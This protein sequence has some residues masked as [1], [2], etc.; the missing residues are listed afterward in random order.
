M[1]LL[2]LLLPRLPSLVLSCSS[3]AAEFSAVTP[4]GGV[5][6]AAAAVCVQAWAVMEGKEGDLSLAR[7]L[8]LDGLRADPY[9][10]AL[11]TVYAIIERQDGSD[12]KARKVGQS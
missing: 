12:G 9:H 8:V 11:W 1:L 10:G 6:A 7:K 2:V 4:A 5:G 3:S